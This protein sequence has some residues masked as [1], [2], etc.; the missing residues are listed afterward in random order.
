MKATGTEVENE[1]ATFKKLGLSESRIKNIP[2]TWSQPG[3][4]SWD[5]LDSKVYSQEFQTVQSRQWKCRKW[6]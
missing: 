4:I 6:A 1:I 3:Q 2:V 5:H